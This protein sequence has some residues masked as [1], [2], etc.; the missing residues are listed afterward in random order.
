[1]VDNTD[2]L[3]NLPLA[4]RLSRV[5]RLWKT[6][7]CQELAPLGLTHSR[8]TAL[9]K[10]KQLGDN[11]SQKVLANALEI[12]LGSLMRT[13]GQLE[14]QGLIIRHCCENDKR[15]RLIMMTEQGHQILNE[16]ES[17]VMNVRRKILADI[18]EDELQILGDILDRIAH[19]AQQSIDQ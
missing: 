8:W 18:S 2:V 9:W 15:A 3:K 1:M 12:E 11:I 19:N 10:I 14:E 7:A 5:A 16:I 13:L 4:E 17:K 6:V